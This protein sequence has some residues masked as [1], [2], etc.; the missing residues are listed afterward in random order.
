MS[1]R[2][3][4][5]Q[6]EQRIQDAARQATGR[7][8]ALNGAI[9]VK[10]SLWPTIAVRDVTFKIMPGDR[11]AIIGPNGAGKTTYFNLISGQLPASEGKVLL[12]GE[13]VTGDAAPVRTRKGMG[14]A[15]QQFIYLFLSVLKNKYIESH[16][17]K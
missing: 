5:D 14:R 12:Y 2:E 7:D 3:R 9:G 17:I 15:F 4:I 11:K 8:L 1:L 10:L 13:D 16:L 6:V